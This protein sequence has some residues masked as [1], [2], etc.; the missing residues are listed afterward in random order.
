MAAVFL[1]SALAAQPPE[2]DASP[3]PPGAGREA[4]IKVCSGCHGAESAVAQ[5][6]THEEWVKTLDEMANN[7]AQGSD[8]EWTQIQSYVDKHFSLIFINKATAEDLHTTLDVPLDVAEAVVRR[9]T[10]KGPF[11]SID[12]LKAVPALPAASVEA[13]KDRFIF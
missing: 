3:F 5:F 1:G 13:R 2:K 6:K 8:E 10:E 11:R 7:G 4:L 12:D 9:R